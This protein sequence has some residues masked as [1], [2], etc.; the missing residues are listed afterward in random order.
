MTGTDGLRP[1]DIIDGMLA[2]FGSP[3][4]HAIAEM[5]KRYPM[6]RA[7]LMEFAAAWAEE[8]H[9]PPSDPTDAQDSAFA[10]AR[11]LF[12]SALAGRA[13]PATLSA[14]ARAVGQSLQDL[15]HRCRFD[16]AVL[17]K[18]DAGAID[19][20]SLGNVLPARLADM[21]GLARS[22]IVAAFAGQNPHFAAAFLPTELAA[23]ESL[24]EALQAAG[25]DPSV[26]AEFDLP[27]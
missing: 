23:G 15:A 7:F 8:A 24:L 27:V 12:A 4:P 1:E 9:L 5:A 3:T 11:D 17:R 19:L 25:T 20:D 10:E 2:E 26:I 21:L 6:Q 14:L 22:T 16:V 13:A 18:L